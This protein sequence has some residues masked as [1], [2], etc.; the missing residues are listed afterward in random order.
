M[1]SEAKCL[2]VACDPTVFGDS[3]RRRQRAVLEEFRAKVR[4]VEELPDGYAFQLAPEPY[5]LQLLAELISFES[6]CCRFLDF[7]LDV[8]GG[9]ASVT[10][11]LTG[12]EGAKDFLR[13]EL[14]LR[15]DARDA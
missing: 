9:G 10:L 14:S 1:A 2:P 15:G 5:M 8:R 7:R 4:A 12:G 3:E 6:R 11:S 13:E